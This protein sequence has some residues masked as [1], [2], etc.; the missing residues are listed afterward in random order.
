MKNHIVSSDR[1]VQIPK[2]TQDSDEAPFTICM[3]NAGNR[4]VY[5]QSTIAGAKREKNNYAI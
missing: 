2:T 5:G 1:I 3:H 4:N